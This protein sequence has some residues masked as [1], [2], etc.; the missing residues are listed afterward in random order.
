MN[1]RTVV[2]ALLLICLL[3]VAGLVD[4]RGWEGSQSELDNEPA[5]VSE[6]SGCFEIRNNRFL[7]DKCSGKTWQLIAV[8]DTVTKTAWVP[9]HRI[10]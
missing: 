1:R 6:H 8:S 10:D 5:W 4:V 7:L 9:I 2:I 3:T